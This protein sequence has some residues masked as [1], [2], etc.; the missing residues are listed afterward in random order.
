MDGLS[1]LTREGCVNTAVMRA[2]LDEALAGLGFPS[3]Y[4][5]VN[6]G[7]LPATDGRTGYPTPTVLYDGRDLFGFPEPTPPY[8][9]PG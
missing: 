6:L 1:F 8:A 7:T 3:A 5:L 9:Q 2:R 4:R